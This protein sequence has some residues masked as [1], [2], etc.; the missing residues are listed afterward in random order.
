MIEIRLPKPGPEIENATITA[1]EC[2]EGDKILIGDIL[3]IIK[4][5]IGSFKVAAEE[6]G[7]LESILQPNG[8]VINFEEPIAIL[9][10]EL[11][12]SDFSETAESYDSTLPL[13]IDE[14]NEHEVT[15]SAEE[16]LDEGKIAANEEEEPEKAIVESVKES[17][18]KEPAQESIKAEE[19]SLPL[20]DK[21]EP[22]TV[23]QPTKKLIPKREVS[24]AARKMAERMGIDLE[25]I[26]GT[27]D[28]GKILYIDI[29]NSI[30]E[31]EAAEKETTEQ[32]VQ[33]VDPINKETNTASLKLDENE[34]TTEEL[35]KQAAAEP[36][37][38]T[39]EP[40]EESEYIS[41]KPFPDYEEISVQ[42]HLAK[43]DDL[44]IPFNTVKKSFSEI[45]AESSRTVPHF[46]L[47]ADIDFTEASKW[48][49]DYNLR[50]K[51]NITVTDLMV[52]ACGHAL[53]L[54]PEINAFVRPD[55]IILKRSINIGVTTS[56][57][58]G[59]VTP[60]VP[61]VYH[62]SLNKVS[63]VIQKNTDLA[64]TSKV[65]LDYDTTFTVSNL[66]MYGVKRFIPLVAT[67]QSA[68]LGIGE[69]SRKVVPIDDFIGIRSIMELTLS[70]DHRAIDGTAAA[71]FIQT[72]RKDVESLIP[73]EDPD[74]IKGNEQLRLI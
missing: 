12:I 39:T 21:A 34:V 47:F 30:R 6:Q 42:F 24:P 25:S 15:E 44:I 27:G 59:V 9:K 62:K 7:I 19:E 66:G 52:K 4:T 36:V 57:D 53:A 46:H 18:Q 56:V 28:N 1:W 17:G 14:P 10:P 8:S 60:V 69:I 35:V 32:P 31:T 29:E 68:T 61:D 40:A 45:Q 22:E 20:E 16:Q 43:K 72:V 71:R 58:E 64:M 63:D 48:L 3:A 37:I 38:E 23:Q 74:W 49:E 54:M 5:P 55:R 26:E 51:S 33:I 73:D 67:P 13:P 70:C 50:N 41:N 11:K 2:N 65:V